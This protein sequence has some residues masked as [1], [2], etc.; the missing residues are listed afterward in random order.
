MSD[1]STGWDVLH[2]A[3]EQ[4]SPT[5][6]LHLI[7]EVARSLRQPAAATDPGQRI[8]NLD[9]LRHDLAALPTRNPAD[10]FSGREHDR[11]L[12]GEPR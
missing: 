10:G 11:I 3:I 1:C 8:A 2:K 7:E 5:E 4:L 9:R 6:R 12:Y